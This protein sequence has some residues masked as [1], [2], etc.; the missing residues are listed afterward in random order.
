MAKKCTARKRMK[1]SEWFKEKMLLAESQEA[2][3]VLNDEQ[4]NFLAD[5]LEET[6]DYCDDK[7]TANAIFMSNLSPVGSLNDDTVAP[8]YDSNIQEQGYIENIV[9]N[10]ESYDELPE[11]NDMILSVI[12]QMKSQVEKYNMVNQE[13][14]SEIESLTSDIERYKDRV[15][16]LGYAVKDGHS[17]QEAYLNREYY[18]VVNDLDEC[19]KRRTTLSPHHIGIWEQ[20]DI[21]G[22]FKNDVIPFSENL[23]EMKDIFEQMEDEENIASDIMYTYL[24]SLNEV[25]NYGKCKSLDIVLLDL[26]ESNKI[27]KIEDENVSLAFQVSSLVKEREHIKLEYKK[28]YDSIKKTRAKIKLQTNSLQ[29]KLNDQN[30]KS[31]KLRAQLKGKFSESQTNQHVTPLPKSKVIPKVVKKNDFSKSFNSYLNTK[32]IIQKCTK[33]L[34][35]GLL[36]I[37]IE[38]INAYFKNNRVVHRDYLKVTKEHV[39]TLQELLDQARELKPLDEHIGRVSSTNASGLKPRSNTK[40]DRIPQPSSKS[41]KNKVD[42]HHRKF[43]SSANKNNH[44]SDCNA[45]V[46]NVSLSKNSDTICLSCNECLKWIPIGRTFNLVGKPCPPSSSNDTSATVV[47]PRPILETIVILV[48]EPCPKLILRYAIARECLTRSMVNLEFHPLNIHEFGF[49]GILRND[50]LP[51]W[52]FDYLRFTSI[53]EIVWYLD[54]GYSKHMTGHRNKLVNFVSKFIGTVRFENDHFVAIMGYG[55]LQMRNILIPRVYYIEGLGHNLF[56]IGQFCDSD[57][58]VAF[59]K[60]TCFVRNL[61]GVDLQSGSRDSN[62]YTISMADMMKS[63]LIFLLFKASKTNSCQ[64]GK[65]KKKS[66]PHKSE[67]STNKKL[68]MLHMDLCGPMQFLRTKDEALEIIIKFL[69]QAQVSLNAT[70][71]ITHNTSAARTPQQKG[72]VERRNRTL[73][74]ATRTMLI[75]S[76]SSLFL[77][78]EA[79]ATACYTQNRSII[80]TRYNKTPYELLRDRKPELKY[81]HIFWALCY[82]INDFE[83]LG[84]LQPKPDIG[85]FIGYSPF[86][87]AY[88]IYNKR[89]RQIM[90]TMNVQFDELT[91]MASEQHCSGPDLQE[92]TF[93]QISSKLVLNQNPSVVSTPIF[94]ATLPPPDI[95]RASSSSSSTSIDKDAPSDNRESLRI[96]LSISEYLV[97]ILGLPCC[98]SSS[99]VRFLENAGEIIAASDVD[100]LM[101]VVADGAQSPQV[102]VPFPKDPYKAIRQAYLVRTDTES[103]PFDDPVETKT[104]KSPHMVAPPTLLSNSTPPMRHTKDS[105]DSDTFGARSMPSDSTT[106][107]SPD[108]P[109]THASPTLVPFL[110]RTARMVVRVPP[111]MS[112]GLSASIADVVAMSDSAFRKRFRSSYESSPSSSPPD[113]PSRK[114]YQG[115]SELVE[116]DEEEGDEEEDKEIEE[117]SDSDSGSENAEDEGPTV[118]DEDPAA[119]EEGLVAGDE[120]PGMRVESLSVGGG[121]VVPEGQQ[122]AAPFVETAIGEPLRLGYG[123]LRRREIALGEGRMPSVFEVGQSSG[124]VP[125]SER[126][127]KES[128]SPSPEWSSGS[129]PVSLAPFIV[130]SPISSHMRPLTVP[131]PVA[132]PATAETEG[133]LTELGARVE[134]QGGLICD[135]M[136][137]LGELLPTLFERYDRDIGELFTRSGAVK[138]MHREQLCGMP[139]VIRK[140][141]NRELRIQI[142]EERRARLDLAEIVDSM[143]RGQEPRGDV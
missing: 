132:S 7:A 44:V 70:V 141:E 48:V 9:S 64:M 59:R 35:R 86:K 84:K 130:P 27:Q 28:L 2:G 74:E 21:K 50:D 38:P 81:L 92:L 116:D 73:V 37:E 79:I 83:D 138:R 128:T 36:K 30:S 136:V 17:E 11:K 106:P 90:E 32:N 77:L 104:P 100:R 31:N 71:G 43:K 94:A 54:S 51:P 133:F 56:S 20:S 112:P 34:A 108:H 49:E 41:K 19:I 80:H 26:Q 75:F 115:T 72:V 131:S 4:Q 95:A 24:R 134:M 87:K 76:K 5:S 99:S 22:A 65:S 109:L 69:K 139:L 63:S 118:E 102:P 111:A 60:H 123:A 62:I 124:F 25:D 66:H 110:H 107:L 3:V 127:K 6:D 117:S 98:H 135:H 85:I 105:V 129:L 119:R 142:A 82:P 1:D 29:Q 57:L 122:R 15:R 52:K 78:A 14:Q 103:E 55:D 97:G 68:Q 137:R 12:E 126:S 23:K 114:H 125:E 18:T 8:R 67:P 140:R 121:E 120:G 91:H 93:G 46:K 58:E 39:A 101:L 113:L 143:R 96:R 10:N 42:A 89:T 45:N 47:S 40:N 16:V 53:V 13:K 61:E 88:R 33:V